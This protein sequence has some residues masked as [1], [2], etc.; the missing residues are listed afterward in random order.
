MRRLLVALP[1]L[2]PAVPA[3][4]QDRAPDRPAW[5]F[6]ATPYV[7]AMGA[8]G[9]VTA[10]GQTLD[11]SAGIVDILGKTDTLIAQPAPRPVRSASAACSARNTGADRP[12]GGSALRQM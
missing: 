6:T 9:N 8:S 5:T 10:R 7:W 12:A 3:E 11:V 2:V 4:A 1:A